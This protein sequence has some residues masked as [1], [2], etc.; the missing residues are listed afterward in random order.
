[1]KHAILI[2]T[3]NVSINQEFDRYVKEI[4]ET[5]QDAIET[6]V[7]ERMVQPIDAL[8]AV[9][10]SLTLRVW[11]YICRIIDCWWHIS[12]RLLLCAV[13]MLHKNTKLQFLSSRCSS[14]LKTAIVFWSLESTIRARNVVWT[15]YSMSNERRLFRSFLIVCINSSSLLF[16]ALN[17]RD[18]R[19]FVPLPL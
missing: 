3:T 4:V 9:W 5:L 15:A 8:F 19:S 16:T 13:L 17:V 6:V 12:P 2:R 10:I 11:L 1:M 18:I 14:N 7:P